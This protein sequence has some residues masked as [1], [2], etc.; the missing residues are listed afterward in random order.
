MTEAESNTDG[1]AN[2][3]HAADVVTYPTKYRLAPALS[4]QVPLV[5]IIA[6]I[7]TSILHSCVNARYTEHVFNVLI[8]TASL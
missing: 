8:K 4:Q 5:W 7:L 2:G 1:D 6:C 3:A